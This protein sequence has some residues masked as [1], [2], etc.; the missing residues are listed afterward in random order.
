MVRGD[1]MEKK[2]SLFTRILSAVGHFLLSIP[3]G[4][5]NWFV[6]KYKAIKKYFTNLCD[7]EYRRLKKMNTVKAPRADKVFNVINAVVMV[8]LIL[9]VVIPLLYLIASA[10]SDGDAQTKV[11]FLPKVV[12]EATGNIKTGITFDHFKYILFDYYL[13]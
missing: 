7:K 10:F 9:L 2:K 12:D 8:L 11:I 3:R 6:N 1:S 5:K 4:I 13:S